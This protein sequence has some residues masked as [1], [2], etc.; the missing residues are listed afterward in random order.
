MSSARLPLPS[1]ICVAKTVSTEMPGN[2]VTVA[3]GTA[4]WFW[5]SLTVVISLTAPVVATSAAQLVRSA[6]PSSALPEFAFNVPR[7]LLKPTSAASAVVV[8]SPPPHAARGAIRKQARVRRIGG[9]T[10]EEYLSSGRL[11]LQPFPG[12]G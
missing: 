9:S 11:R 3:C 2:A 7:G 8:S 5:K 12:G 10:P 4:V 6:S 1:D